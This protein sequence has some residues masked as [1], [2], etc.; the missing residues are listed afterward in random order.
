AICPAAPSRCASHP[1][2]ATALGRLRAGAPFGALRWTAT[3]APD[4]RLEATLEAPDGARAVLWL[5]AGGGGGYRVEG[6]PSAALR[7]GLRAALDALR[8]PKAR[9]ASPGG[10]T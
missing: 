8:A 1:R 7:E 5:E 9:A 6:E 4:D 3:R 10:P 2:L